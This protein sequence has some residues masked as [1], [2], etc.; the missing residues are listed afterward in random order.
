MEP[1]EREIEVAEGTLEFLRARGIIPHARYPCEEFRAYR[2]AVRESFEIH[3]TGIS[4]RMQRLIYALNAIRQPAVMVAAGIPGSDHRLHR[5]RRPD[6]LL[7]LP[8]AP[9]RLV[10]LVILAPAVVLLFFT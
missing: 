3:S 6:P 1:L 10:A 9:G 8:H 7:V 5:R 4:P 2:E